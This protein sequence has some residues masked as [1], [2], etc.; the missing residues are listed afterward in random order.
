MMRGHT[1]HDTRSTNCHSI[2]ACYKEVAD[3]SQMYNLPSV[4]LCSRMSLRYRRT[5]LAALSGTTGTPGSGLGTSHASNNNRSCKINNNSCN[6]RSSNRRLISLVM[7]SPVLIWSR[8]TASSKC[9]IQRGSAG[10][11]ALQAETAAL[12][13]YWRVL[14]MRG[15]TVE[16]VLA[17]AKPILVLVRTLLVLTERTTT[18]QSGRP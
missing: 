4:P 11:G 13:L 5:Y 8:A 7:T 16:K 15:R 17:R 12:F 9:T 2:I 14:R 10:D 3:V 1:L 18:H 6:R